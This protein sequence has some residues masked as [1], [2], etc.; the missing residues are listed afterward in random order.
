MSTPEINLSNMVIIV[1]EN[2]T[3]S[4]G[5]FRLENTTFYGAP[6]KW[7]MWIIMKLLK[8]HPHQNLKRKFKK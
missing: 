2:S 7:R 8:S 5:N 6:K 4:G 3:L 1:K